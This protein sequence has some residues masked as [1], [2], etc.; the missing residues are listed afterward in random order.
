MWLT[1]KVRELASNTCPPRS[2]AVVSH[3][4]ITTSTTLCFLAPRHGGSS[5]SCSSTLSR[6]E[7]WRAALTRHKCPDAR[8]ECNRSRQ[9]GQTGRGEESDERRESNVAATTWKRAVVTVTRTHIL[10]FLA[11]W[12][13]R[14]SVGS[15]VARRLPGR[16]SSVA[17]SRCAAGLDFL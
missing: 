1:K 15:R 3:A 17:A 9:S 10:L 2:P 8:A 11:R 14:S 7:Q 6:K 12:V 5:A 16:H 13:A 4:S